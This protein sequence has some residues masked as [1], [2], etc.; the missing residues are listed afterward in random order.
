MKLPK[1]RLHR[2]Y[3]ANIIAQA[4]CFILN[5]G[6]YAYT[7]NHIFTWIALATSLFIGFVNSH[8]KKFFDQS[9]F[10]HLIVIVVYYFIAAL[11]FSHHVAYFALIFIFT[12]VFF[13]LKDS[14]FDKSMTLWTYIQALVVATTFTDFPF[15]QKILATIIAYIEAQL[16]LN[17]FFKFMPSRIKYIPE[18]SIFSIWKMKLSDWTSIYNSNVQLALRGSII[19]GMIYILCSTIIPND[20]KPN[21]AAISAV[22]CL[23]RNDDIASINSM[24]STGI[25][26]FLGWISSLFIIHFFEHEVELNLALLWVSLLL[27]LICI[28]EFRRTQ[29]RIA[30]ILSVMFFLMTVTCMALIFDTGGKLYL[31]L[32]IFNT[33]IGVIGAFIALKIWRKMQTNAQ[34]Y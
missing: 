7:N 30:Q 13:I 33:I 8:G 27:G 6:L 2:E 9:L 10:N 15:S 26:S 14:G 24:V 25:G 29:N 5:C 4:V 1:P 3:R 23:L 16:I 17:I 11:L 18:K 20:M 21:W 19:A 31:N 32:K 12:Y 22:S 34:I 28:F